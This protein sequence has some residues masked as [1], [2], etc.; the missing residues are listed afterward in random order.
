[1]NIFLSASALVIV[2]GVS[3]FTSYRHGHGQ[4]IAFLIGFILLISVIGHYLS[5][6]VNDFNYSKL[7]VGFILYLSISHIL[8]ALQDIED[9]LL[10]K[11]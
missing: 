10:G 5:A 1:L 7:Q 2:T 6:Q 11:R 9:I 3:W 4:G 8:Y